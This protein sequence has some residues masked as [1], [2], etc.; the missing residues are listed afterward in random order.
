MIWLYIT[1]AVILVSVIAYY[2]TRMMK[3]SIK[4]LMTKSSFGSGENVT[5]RFQLTSKKSLQGDLL[6][7]SL[8]GKETVRYYDGDEEKTR[9]R[10]YYRDEV[11]LEE[12]KNY[13][14]GKSTKYEFEISYPSQGPSHS[15]D[16]SMD[17]G[18][19]KVAEVALTAAKMIGQ[20]SQD[21]HR[22]RI[23]WRVE[24]RLEMKGVDLADSKKVYLNN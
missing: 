21:R 5:G 14:A 16:A 2:V 9:T 1:V 22:S 20:M 4:I 3:G 6:K 23:D 11:I 8:I 10:E 18:N 19:S 7:A 15:V 13:P 17:V 12:G 24:V